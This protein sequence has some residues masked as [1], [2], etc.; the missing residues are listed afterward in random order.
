MGRAGRW[1]RENRI[2]LALAIAVIETLLVVAG[3]L[4]WF[5]VVG[6]AAA[7][8][9][10]WWL[11][12]RY[13]RNALVRQ[14]TATLALSQV[15]PLVAPLVIATLLALLATAV[16]IAVLVVLVVGVIAVAAL[17]RRRR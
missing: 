16:A 9:A 15:I 11:A 13:A 7:A 8:I 2:R 17:V 10:A 3:Q 1:L 14:A 5:W 6:F 4:R 12:R